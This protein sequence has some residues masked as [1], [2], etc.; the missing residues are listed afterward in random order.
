MMRSDL[1][2]ASWPA[3]PQQPAPARRISM[4]KPA[5]AGN[6]R[7]QPEP[8]TKWTAGS[9]L[10]GAVVFAHVLLFATLIA[11]SRITPL[12]P[13]EPPVPIMVS[14]VSE[15]TPEPQ[16]VPAPP[17]PAPVIKKIEP[18]HAAPKPIK[19]V[20]KPEPKPL[21]KVEPKPTPKPEPQPVAQV[22]PPPTPTVPPPVVQ[23][24]PPAPAEQPAPVA[25]DASPAP[26]K[27]AEAVEKSPAPEPVV[28]PPSFGAA[29]LH[30]PPPRYPTLSRRMGEEGRV[31]LRVH[32]TENGDAENVEIEKGSGS[33]R[34]DEAAL[35]AVRKW[36][37]VP[38]KRDNQ[39]VSAS[40]LVP[41]KF[42]LRD[43]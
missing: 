27:Q 24:T 7:L 12:P 29:Y 10:L 18:K 42:S 30:N 9:L 19:Q 32:V 43:S 2:L 13:E 1:R 8:N 3:Q 31:L 20:S 41:M 35:E 38:A 5:L 6:R 4:L 28:V 26:T 39:A 17:K 33:E 14:L 22:A 37:F 36:K 34:L 25:E 40:V 16:A 15:P 11:Q 23:Q 21:P